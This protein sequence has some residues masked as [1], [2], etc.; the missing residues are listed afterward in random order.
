MQVDHR[1][2]ALVVDAL[3]KR[4][5]DQRVLNDITLRVERGEVCAVV[6]PSGGGKTTFLRCLN[7][8][9]DFDGGRI[10]LAGVEDVQRVGRAARQ[11][12]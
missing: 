1:E 12:H 3:A 9:E 11:P 10:Q 8:L 7:G 6:G 4:F 2:P 5:A